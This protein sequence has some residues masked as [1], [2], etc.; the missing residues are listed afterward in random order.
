MNYKIISD[1]ASDMLSLSGV[2]YATVPLKIITSE[3]EYIDD[4]NLD[5]EGMLCDLE[6]YSGRS[7]SACPNI[8]EW[9]DAFEGADIIFCVTITS[10]LSGSYNTAE[11][12]LKEYLENN[13]DCK[14]AVIDSLSTGPEG[15]LIIE[16][17]KELILAELS[18]EEI[19]EKINEY[20]S[21]T[22]LLYALESLRNLANNGRISGVSAKIAG[23]LGIRVIGK[24][25]IVGTLELLQ[26]VRGSEKAIKSIVEYID[27]HG[28]SGG[29]I[30]IHHCENRKAAESIKAK[31]LE[32]YPSAEV[33][34][35]KTGALCSFYAER[36]G[37]LVGFE[38][39]NKSELTT[40]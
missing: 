8:G 19:L 23:I 21:S 4:T 36:G 2:S 3:K 35:A 25:S 6:K 17:L 18:F 30:R 10:N 39:I 33:V 16:K 40:K 27:A 11:S 28:Y 9:Q 34:I 7:G 26:K 12:A 38:G 24:A 37:I 1:S 22:H 5:L 20:K 15:C 32:K 14:G 29:K 31:I 13:P